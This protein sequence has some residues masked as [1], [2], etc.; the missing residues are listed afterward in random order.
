ML[1]QSAL[2]IAPSSLSQS[3]LPSLGTLFD[4]ASLALHLPLLLALLF[5][6]RVAFGR[7]LLVSARR[8]LRREESILFIPGVGLQIEAAQ[9]ADRVD[10]SGDSSAP[11]PPIALHRCTR[12]FIDVATVQSVL[13]HEA[14]Q[15]N[16]VRYHLIILI[17][18]K[19]GAREGSIVL[20]FE[21]RT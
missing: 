3:S 7:S 4:R 16:Q 2:V 15:H 6:A 20:P 8:R 19:S 5:L 14:I 21:V 9:V 11:S 18:P 12:R 1:T 13:L 10:G 17:K